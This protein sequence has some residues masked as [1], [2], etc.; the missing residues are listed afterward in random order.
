MSF[1]HTL[2]DWLRKPPAGARPHHTPNP[3][4]H[5]GGPIAD[6]RRS[7][8]YLHGG[9]RQGEITNP[10]L[11]ARRT[12]NEHTSALV[13][14]RQTWQVIGLLSMLIA[15]AAVGGLVY[16]SSQSRLVPYVVQVDKHGQAL[17][18][19]PL[20]ATDRTDPRIVRAMVAEFISDA[21]TVTPDTDLLRKNV[22]R[23]YAHLAANDP[24]TARMNEWLNSTEEASPFRRAARE[25]VSVDIQST[26]P[27][28]ESTWQVDWSEQV[29]DRQGQPKG[30]A[31]TH[32]ALL[33][34]Y[35]SPSV[36]APSN[37]QALRNN[38]LGLFVREFSWSRLP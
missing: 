36:H 30:T 9:R 22:F 26:L 35:S 29:R 32:R 33:T 28:S 7:G 6:P 38:P 20:S 37:E 4:V 17:A 25:M 23:L 14:Q 24:A 27:V 31:M 13:S 1:A 15:L 10:Y 21:R 18:Q 5:T 12:W 11:A 8:T 34:V 19:G 2:R 3:P 16:L